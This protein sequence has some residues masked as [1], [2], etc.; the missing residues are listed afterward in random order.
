MAVFSGVI[1]LA[2]ILQ[3]KGVEGKM[4]RISVWLAFFVIRN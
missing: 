4:K 3:S 1:G 2:D